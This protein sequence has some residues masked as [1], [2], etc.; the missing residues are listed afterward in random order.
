MLRESM[1]A[2]AALGVRVKTVVEQGGLIDNELMTEVVVGRLGEADAAEGFLLDGFPRTVPQAQSLDDIVAGGGALIVVEVALEEA[3]VLR[4]LA[5][6][7]VCGECGA[8]AQDDRDYSTCHDCGGALIPRSDDA[9]DVV[10][11]RLA[12]YREQTSPLV[13]Y[14]RKRPTFVRVDGAQL[15]DDVT[16]AIVQGVKARRPD[17]DRRRE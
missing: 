1:R 7:L 12:V 4:R 9:A 16:A 2:G 14:Y 11:A 10:H 17:V 3:E 13:D 6:R 8:N 15:V 5:A